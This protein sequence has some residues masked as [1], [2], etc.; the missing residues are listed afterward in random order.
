MGPIAGGIVAALLYDFVLASNVSMVK[1]R[2]MLMASDFDDGVY[3]A[4]KTK[5]KV[6]EDDAESAGFETK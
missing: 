6:V 2:D 5:V 1:A 3:P 4:R